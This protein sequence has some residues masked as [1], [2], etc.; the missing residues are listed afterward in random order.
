VRYLA[1]LFLVLIPVM[2]EA[3]P[4]A[5]MESFQR[6]AVQQ[7]GPEQGPK[8]ANSMFSNISLG[9]A[10][11]ASWSLL[12]PGWSQYRA[13]NT[14]RA[15]L[16]ASFEAAIWSIF[17][18]SKVQGNS[19]EDTYQQFAQSFAGVGN[20]NQ[21]DDYWKAVGKHKDSDEYNERVRRENR[22]AAEEQAINGEDV[23]IGINDGTVASADAW[24]W[25]SGNRLLEYRELRSD[26]QGAYDRADA[27]L[28]FAIVNRLVAFIE[29]FRTGPGADGDN[30]IELYERAGFELSVE[31][32]PNPLRPS[33][34]LLFGRS[35]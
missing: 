10:G 31:V 28:F 26:A 32:D 24:F 4:A 21:D 23:T 25:T 7:A 2:A 12:I 34:A 11:H 3:N 18:V 19:R 5:Q 6:A 29:A 17:A 14:G 35:F 30:Q 9:R 22:A 16:F 33:G 13:G 15:F 8:P 20:T 27:M 1:I